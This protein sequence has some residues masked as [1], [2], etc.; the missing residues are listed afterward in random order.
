MPDLRGDLRS[1]LVDAMTRTPLL[2]Q[3]AKDIDLWPMRRQL[4]ASYGI[5]A[6][7]PKARAQQAF[8]AAKAPWLQQEIWR[9]DQKSRT[10]A[11]GPHERVVPYVQERERIGD[12]LR[13]GAEV[14]VIGPPR[15]R[16]QV[17]SEITHTGRFYAHG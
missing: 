15:L 16:Q 11:A 4:G 5:F 13:F 14:E 3:A 6:R 12:I 10:L 7:S 9:P 8:S 1:S 2:D 17:A